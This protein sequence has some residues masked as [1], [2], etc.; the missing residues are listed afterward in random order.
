MKSL[1]ET[2][3]LIERANPGV[4][5]HRAWEKTDCVGPAYLLEHETKHISEYRPKENYL[6]LFRFQTFR[7]ADRIWNLEGVKSDYITMDPPP[8]ELPVADEFSP[9]YCKYMEAQSIPGIQPKK[10]KLYVRKMCPIWSDTH[11][12]RIIETWLPVYSQPQSQMLCAAKEEF[13]SEIKRQIREVPSC[14]H[15]NHLVDIMIIV[16]NSDEEGYVTFTPVFSCPTC[17]IPF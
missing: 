11:P 12:G 10:L 16:S 13:I 7:E 2:V 17:G 14:S 15:N 8:E 5:I 1:T 6:Y 3:S 9:P 4:K